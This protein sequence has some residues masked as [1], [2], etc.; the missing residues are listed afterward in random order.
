M[1][2][3]AIFEKWHIGDGNYPPLHRGQQ[4]NLSFE[5]N[6]S[7][8][9]KCAAER[10]ESFVDL[11]GGEYDFTGTVLRTYE[12]Q[13]VTVVRSGNFRFYVNRS[14]ALKEGDQVRGKGILFLDRYTWV[15]FLHQYPN[16][17]DL[18]YQ[19]RIERIRRV[20]IPEHYVSR[21]RQSKSL[22]TSLAPHDYAAEHVSE[23]ETMEG[24]DSD[25]QFYLLDLSDEGVSGQVARTFI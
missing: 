24:E 5:I 6:P 20:Q 4:V 12:P 23:I 13:A 17:P 11:G 16:P 9:E 21:D 2:L 22:P 15:E 3:T 10:A 8:I 18:F 14:M 1:K 19:L 7:D 25:E